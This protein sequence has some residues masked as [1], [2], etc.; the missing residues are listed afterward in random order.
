MGVDDNAYL[1]ALLQ[2]SMENIM[3]LIDITYTSGATTTFSKLLPTNDLGIWCFPIGLKNSGIWEDI[4]FDNT[5]Q[6]WYIVVTLRNGSTI[7][8]NP[9]QIYIDHR[10][11]Y[12]NTEFNFHNSLSGIDNVRILGD[13]DMDV[14]REYKEGEKIVA[15]DYYNAQALPEMDFQR[16]IEERVKYKGDAGWQFTKAAQ[17]HLRELTL[18]ESIWQ[19]Q[20]KKNRWWKVNI[21]QKTIALRNTRSTKWNFPIEWSYAFSNTNYTPYEVDLNSVV[22]SCPVPSGLISTYLGANW[23]QFAFNMPITPQAP[24][25]YLL[26]YKKN[27]DVF[28]TSL[29]VPNPPIMQ[30]LLNNAESYKWRLKSIC[31]GNESG[32]VQGLGFGQETSVAFCPAVTSFALDFYDPLTY[33]F[34]FSIAIPTPFSKVNIRVVT[35]SGT[36]MYNNLTV[37]LNKVT[38]AIPSIG[39]GNYTFS[40]QVVCDAALS[41]FGAFSAGVLFNLASG[42]NPFTITKLTSV[43]ASSPYALLINGYVVSTGTI[44]FGTPVTGN[45]F[46]PG[47]GYNVE[48]QVGILQQSGLAANGVPPDSFTNYVAIWNGLTASSLNVQF[49]NH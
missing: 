31:D 41:S 16:A 3:L 19:P 11:F 26:S 12:D 47:T 39:A 36:V 5:Q 22:T 7:V 25:Q 48:L 21:L 49:R 27:G 34:T 37:V 24:S 43:P 23:Y 6:V 17:D 1:C 44:A 28:W 29:L 33:T 46:L 30:L 10:K 38:V 14:E 8:C 13:V 45:A 9:Y 2:T 4:D 40:A 42:L 20:I 18:S 32:F 15:D 35:P